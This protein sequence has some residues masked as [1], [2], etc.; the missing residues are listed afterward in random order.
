MKKRN[1]IYLVISL[2]LLLFTCNGMDPASMLPHENEDGLWGYRDIKSGKYILKAKYGM[3]FPFINNHAIVG[4]EENGQFRYG[5]IDTLGNYLLQPVYDF[6][7]FPKFGYYVVKEADGVKVLDT[8]LCEV[9]PSKYKDVS[10]LN[11]EYALVTIETGKGLYNLNKQEEILPAL[12]DEITVYPSTFIK[13]KEGGKFGYF[14]K[15]GQ[16]I[17]P[18]KYDYPDRN[19]FDNGY[20]LVSCNGHSAIIDTIGNEFVPINDKQI[21]SFDP[22]SK[23]FLVCTDDRTYAYNMDNQLIFTGIYRGPSG[24]QAYHEGLMA[25][26]NEKSFGFIDTKGQLVIPYMYDFVESFGFHDGHA[27]VTKDGQIAVIDKEN[28]IILPFTSEQYYKLLPDSAICIVNMKNNTHMLV[29]N[30]LNVIIPSKYNEIEYL[31]EG[32]YKVRSDKLYGMVDKSGNEILPAQY[33][34]IKRII[35]GIAP[36]MDTN[37]KFGLYNTRTKQ[38]IHCR[39]SYY[40]IDD[41]YMENGFALVMEDSVISEGNILLIDRNGQEYTVK[42]PN[43]NIFR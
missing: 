33:M 22:V 1:L 26:T 24:T 4:F 12:Y 15:E 18:I 11:Q 9:L 34:D 5:L 39:H 23:L 2:P 17:T 10:I 19:D 43:H 7:K 8:L 42:R 3:A 31:G 16:G 20:L 36:F 40:K 25:F 38:V 41:V 21:I 28:A 30:R 14:N 27:T 32:Y 29:D 6:I 37:K 13:V 35:D